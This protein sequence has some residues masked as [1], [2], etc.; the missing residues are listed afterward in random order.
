[1]LEK[2]SMDF[3]SPTGPTLFTLLSKWLEKKWREEDGK[4]IE[5]K[6]S[7]KENV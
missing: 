4:M 5:N 6:A 2:N 3:Y 1:M 7:Q